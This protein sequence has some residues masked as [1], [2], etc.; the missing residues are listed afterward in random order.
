MQHPIEVTLDKF[1]SKV[2]ARLVEGARI[3][4]DASLDLPVDNLLNEIEQE[5]EDV[6]GWSVLLWAK[7]ERL[8]ERL[9]DNDEDGA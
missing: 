5:L 7:L 8:R 3:Y 1:V 2:R 9:R 4:G 6:C